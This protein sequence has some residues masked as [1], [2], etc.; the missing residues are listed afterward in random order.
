MTPTIEKGYSNHKMQIH[1]YKILLKIEIE[2]KKV[3]D[4]CKLITRGVKCD[5]LT[6]KQDLFTQW[7]IKVLSMYCFFTSDEIIT[8]VEKQRTP[9]FLPNF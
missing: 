8:I 6:E 7:L 9:F 2:K 5:S 4:I 1:D 3:I